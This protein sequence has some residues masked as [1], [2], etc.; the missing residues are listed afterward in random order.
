LN[1]AWSCRG[2]FCAN[3]FILLTC[4][5]LQRYILFKYFNS[6]HLHGVAEEHF[7]TNILILLTCM[8]L[9][10]NILYKCFNSAHLHG[11]AEVL[12]AQVGNMVE[13]PEEQPDR[14]GFPRWA[15]ASPDCSAGTGGGGR[16]LL[17]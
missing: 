13:L 9:Q 1:C 5:E 2:K 16:Q 3:I 11:I 15:A 14:T 6:A 17:S 4:I 10:E 12:Q 7:W 8:E